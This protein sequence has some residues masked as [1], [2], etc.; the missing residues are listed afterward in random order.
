MQLLNMSSEDI[1]KNCWLAFLLMIL[2]VSKACWRN[3]GNATK[4]FTKSTQFL[5]IT[6]RNWEGAYQSSYTAMR[7]LDCAKQLSTN[8]VGVQFCLMVQPLG[9]GISSGLVCPM[10]ITKKHTQVL[11]VAIP[12]WMNC[13][14]IWQRRL[15]AC[16]VKDLKLLGLENSTSCGVPTR[17][18]CRPKREHTIANATL[19]A[20]Q[21]LCVYGV[22]QTIRTSLTQISGSKRFG[23][24]LLVMSVRGPT[25]ARLQRYLERGVNSS[26]QRTCSTYAI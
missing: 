14:H 12:C 11:N 8:S 6:N 5:K 13:A 2:R 4:N 7:E 21:I 18:I 20:R 22:Q 19:T 15:P 10:K 26:C 17:G 9:I 23:A 1:L 3:I 16:I 24:P 25:Q